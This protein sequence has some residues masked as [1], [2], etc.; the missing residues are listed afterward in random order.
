MNTASA[1][2]TAS[3]KWSRASR[4]AVRGVLMNHGA[5]AFTWLGLVVGLGLVLG[6]RL[7]LGLC[8]RVG[9]SAS[10]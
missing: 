2:L 7:R 4:G 8:L 3:W 10:P 6:L 1:R 5:T 9:P